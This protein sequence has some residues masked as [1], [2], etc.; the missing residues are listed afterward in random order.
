MQ[1][2]QFFGG[3]ACKAPIS[4]ERASHAFDVIDVDAINDLCG[5]HAMSGYDVNVMAELLKLLRKIVDIRPCS[6]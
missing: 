5:I 6:T 4:C 1:F 3:R 2:F